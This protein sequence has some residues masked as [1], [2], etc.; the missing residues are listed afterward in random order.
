MRKIN[1]IF[2]SLQGEGYHTGTPAIFIRFSGCNLQCSFC[3]TAH[4]EGKLMLDE[5]IIAE[6]QKYP[7]QMVIITG[8]EPALWIDEAFVHLLHQISKYVCV[9]TNGTKTLPQNIDWV[10]CSPKSIDVPM[11][12]HIDE[13]KVV[14]QG[15]HVSSYLNIKAKHHYL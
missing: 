2:Y 7:A 5:E 6:V 8:G 14:Y 12:K 9:E 10:T 3:D 15:Q 1:E 4:E 11:L 13:I